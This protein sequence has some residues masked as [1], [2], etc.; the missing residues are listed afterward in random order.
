MAT[1]P[2]VTCSYCPK[3][4][5]H[6]CPVAEAERTEEATPTFKQQVALLA[7][8]GRRPLDAERARV[9]WKCTD[10]G[11]AQAACRHRIDPAPSLREGRAAAIAA[12][13]APREVDWLRARFAEHGSPYSQDLAAGL[14]PEATARRAAQGPV[15]LFPA[16]TSLAHEPGETAQALALLDRVGP[17]GANLALPRPVCCGYPLDAAGLEPEFRAQAARVAVALSGFEQVVALG[18]ACAYTM[19]YRYPA[20][21]VRPSFGVVPLVDLLAARPAAWRPKPDGPRL[22]W[23]D[24]CFLG[25]RLRRWEEPRAVLRAATG[26]APIEL[27]LA[28][29]E[30]LCSGG[31]GTYPLTHPEPARSC[32]QRVMDA[33]RETGAEA[34]VTGCPSA[35]RRFLEAEP[36]APVLGLVEALA[37]T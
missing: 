18:P 34:L 15:G 30:S 14:A 1:D 33:F 6:A 23:H 29:E 21:G 3:L 13:C 37:T 31:G 9:L 11:A 28:R 16:C 27:P 5:R 19:L 26:R 4:C 2:R 17:R 20:V 25:R 32:A 24:P 7:S 8:T 12:G 10:C 22:A 35:K 36:G